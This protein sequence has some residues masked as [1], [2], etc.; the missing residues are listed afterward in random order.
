VP[1]CRETEEQMTWAA[2]QKVN[3]YFKAMTT[4][5]VASFSVAVTTFLVAVVGIWAAYGR[6]MRSSTSKR[7]PNNLKSKVS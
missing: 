7:R 5:A 1:W 4:E 2:V 6:G 3:Q